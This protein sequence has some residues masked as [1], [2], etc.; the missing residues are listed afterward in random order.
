M[1]IGL[2]WITEKLGG[3]PAKTQR[4]SGCQ[5]RAQWQATNQEFIKNEIS[6]HVRHYAGQEKRIRALEGRKAK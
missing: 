1:N 3:H 5:L 6:Q 2:S 4:R